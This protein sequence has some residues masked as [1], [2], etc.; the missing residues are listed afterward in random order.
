MSYTDGE[1]P[2]IIYTKTCS[3]NGRNA[4]IYERR[5][6]TSKPRMWIEGHE[7]RFN[8]TLVRVKDVELPP[9]GNAT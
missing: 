9:S 4:R 7:Y 8:S 1:P 2:H 5:I 3:R 6:D